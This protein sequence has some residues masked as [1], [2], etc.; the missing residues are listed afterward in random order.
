MAPRFPEITLEA[1]IEYQNIYQTRQI[2]KLVKCHFNS[3]SNI[4]RTF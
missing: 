3:V 2:A 4:L 1:I